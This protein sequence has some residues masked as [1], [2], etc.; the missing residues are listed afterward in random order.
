MNRKR[1][2]QRLNYVTHAWVAGML[3]GAAILAAIPPALQPSVQPFIGAMV[4]GVH[5]AFSLATAQSFW[6]GV[7]GSILAL[8][9]AL[10]IKEIPL[11]TSNEVPVPTRRV[12]EAGAAPG[13]PETVS[14][15][16]AASD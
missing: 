9:A 16:I 12:A 8:L 15:N 6:L 10:A 14:A 4:E 7:V 11:R 2:S 3:L 1:L 5:G 13:Q